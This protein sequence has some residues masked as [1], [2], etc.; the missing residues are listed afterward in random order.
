MEEK[1][2][3]NKSTELDYSQNSPQDHTLYRSSRGF[4]DCA[5]HSLEILKK[6]INLKL[7]PDGQLLPS[8]LIV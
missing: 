1:C 4:E 8:P 2:N 7:C 5:K 3:P 6:T